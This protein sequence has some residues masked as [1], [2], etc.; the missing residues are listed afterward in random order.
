MADEAE[1]QARIA[2]LAGAI[3]RHKQQQQP[4]P[5]AHHAQNHHPYNP[6]PPYRGNHSTT[7]DGLPSQ[8]LEVAA[9]EAMAN[10]SKTERS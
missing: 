1:L 6:T 2:A 5:A 4:E 9:A 10:R 7:I 3:N 8:R